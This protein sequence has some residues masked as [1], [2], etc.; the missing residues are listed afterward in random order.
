MKV[1]RVVAVLV[2]AL[3]PC[4]LARAVTIETVPIGYPGNPADTR[5]VPEGVGSVPYRYRIGKTEVTNEQYIEFL[6]AVAKSDRSDQY[7]LYRPNYYESIVRTGSNGNYSYSLRPPE[8]LENGGTYYFENKPAEFVSFSNAI[9][10]ANWM[11]NGQPTG[12]QD[13]STTEDGAYTLNGA[14]T[15]T[16]LKT[17]N[18]NPGA[19]WWIPNEDE[20]YKAAYYDPELSVYYEYATGTNVAP[21][22]NLPSSDTGNSANYARSEG[23]VGFV[24]TEVG[25][26]TLSASPFGTFDQNGNVDEWNE[27]K[28]LADNQRGYR[29][30]SVYTDR[31][32]EITLQLRAAERYMDFPTIRRG[33]RLATVIP[34]PSTLLLGAVVGFGLLIPRRTRND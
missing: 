11:H 10:F 18:R 24:F 21:D 9:R 33:F 32:H 3:L 31:F 27:T 28:F 8:N 23:T 34:E 1:K 22:R 16:Q 4:T 20:W 14:I 17:V 12:P 2:V 19:R 5:Y 13:A 7:A 6:N 29:G 25:A 30:G 15:I 26:Y